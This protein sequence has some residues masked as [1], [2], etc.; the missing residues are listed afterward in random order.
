MF[1]EFW[2]W[3]W[4]SADF[5]SYFWL[6]LDEDEENTNRI[7]RTIREIVMAEFF[8]SF[9]NLILCNTRQFENKYYPNS[10]T[11]YFNW[12]IYLFIPNTIIKMK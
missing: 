10:E 11:V 5:Y 12:L 7:V 2:N 4:N 9:F 3:V 1:F 6:V 8:I